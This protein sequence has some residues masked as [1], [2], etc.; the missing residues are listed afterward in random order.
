MPLT[1]NPVSRENI[2][3][4]CKLAKDIWN[5]Y[6]PAILPQPQ[7]TYMVEKYQSGPA[8]ERQIAHG[9]QYFFLEREA[10]LIGYC[11]VQPQG[12]RL[13]L[14]KL[15]LKKEWRGKGYAGQAFRYLYRIA[16]EHNLT[17]VWLTVNR[18]NEIAIHAYEK[19]GFETVSEQKTD[20]GQGFYMDDY[21]MEKEIPS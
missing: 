20:I 19:Q 21:V 7:I 11:G 9:Y 2:P 4:L 18:N 14:S 13:F 10:E 5:E 12:D 16:K 1:I 15:Y 6:F 3:T 17:A 8:I